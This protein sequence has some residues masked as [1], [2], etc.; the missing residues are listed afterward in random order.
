MAF[1]ASKRTFKRAPDRNHA[2]RRMR[3]AYRL[4][5]ARFYE[6]LQGRDVGFQGLLMYTGRDL[7]TQAQI[8]KAWRKLLRR[9]D[10]QFFGS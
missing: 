6:W 1:V 3:E 7:P 9:L 4:D 8:T 2:K 5:K 10:P